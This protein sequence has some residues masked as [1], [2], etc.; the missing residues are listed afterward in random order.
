MENQNDVQIEKNSNGKLFIIIVT[1]LIFIIAII[2][3]SYAT[4]TYTKEHDSINTISTGNISLDYTENTNGINLTNVYPMSDEVGKTLTS[5]EQYFDF[6]VKADITGN[7]V[8]NY[9]IAAEKVITSTLS[10]DEV[11]LYLEKE[12]GGSYVEVIAPKNFTPLKESTELGTMVGTMVLTSDTL[13]ESGLINYRLR[14]WVADDTILS[15]V[16]KTFEVRVSIKASVD[17]EKE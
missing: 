11:K 9:E 15:D 7:V 12:E 16:E 10:D 5:E 6:S 14:M 17:L 4:F 1:F 8:A 3:L 2:G 13:D